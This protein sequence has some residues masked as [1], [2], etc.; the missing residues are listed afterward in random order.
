MDT[1]DPALALKLSIQRALLGNVSDRLVSL[2]C[3]LQGRHIEIR[4]YFSP[5]ATER[6]L[7]DLQCVGT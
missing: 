5:I 1:F 7:E 6:D 2:T 4:A 3:G